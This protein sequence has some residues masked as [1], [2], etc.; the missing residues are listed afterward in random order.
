MADVLLLYFFGPM[1]N[2]SFRNDRRPL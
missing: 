1:D 2:V